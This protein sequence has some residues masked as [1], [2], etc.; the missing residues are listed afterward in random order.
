MHFSDISSM[1][2]SVFTISGLSSVPKYVYSSGSIFIIDSLTSFGINILPFLNFVFLFDFIVSGWGCGRSV[3]PGPCVKAGRVIFIVDFPVSGW[4]CGRSLF[5]AS[6]DPIFA[7][8]AALVT[9]VN[10]FDTID[11]QLDD[12]VPGNIGQAPLFTVGVYIFNGCKFR[13][14]RRH[15]LSLF[16]TIF[17][18]FKFL[19]VGCFCDPFHNFYLEFDFNDHK[20][21]QLNVN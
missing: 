5:Q 4:G 13:Y 21:K 10:I 3:N 2:N 16:F 17:S 14:V 19:F 18:D 8:F 20:N 7:F 6:R 11:G 12:S 15:Q 1:S 9:P